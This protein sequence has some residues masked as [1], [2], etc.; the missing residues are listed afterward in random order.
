MA[1]GD[2]SRIA[3]NIAALNSLYSLQNIN[4]Q[5]QTARTRLSTGN[6][7]NSAE[8]DPAGFQF[9]TQFKVR[10]DGMQVATDMIGDA[11][12]LLSVTEGGLTRINDILMNVRDKVLQAAGDT[13][14]SAE[15]SDIMAQVNQYLSQVDTTVDQTKWDNQKLLDGTFS[16]K[17]FRI[18]SD[19]G[20]SI[21]FSFS[22]DHTATG[23][24]LD[25]S[26][27]NTAQSS[28]FA[29]FLASVN[30]ALNT[31]GTSI[32]SVGSTMAR[33]T[34]QEQNLQVAQ[35]NTEASYNRIMNA[36]MAMEQVNASKFQ[37]L[38]QTA[39]AML[40]QANSSPQYILS[41]FR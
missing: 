14:G 12:N 6:R 26:S 25:T 41:L 31:L 27:L 10:S 20:D 8:D 9:A 5:L 15:R 13:I 39:T 21:S 1:S 29:T 16:N 24:G 11:K 35:A 36:N 23:L 18:G 40:A 7:I 32:A 30:T 22:Q 33:L 3:G 38:Q 37:I 28:T 17:N 4:N 19:A 2:L 34:F